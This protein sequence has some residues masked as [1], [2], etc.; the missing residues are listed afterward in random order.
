MNLTGKIMNSTEEMETVTNSE[1]PKES[2]YDEIGR[3]DE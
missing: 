2:V 1:K 3:D